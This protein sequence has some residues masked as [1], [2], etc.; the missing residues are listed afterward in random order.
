MLATFG[1]NYVERAP[2]VARTIEVDRTRARDC[3]VKA[4]KHDLD[5]VTMRIIAETEQR[6]TSRLNPFA[7]LERC[8]LHLYGIVLKLLGD[9]I[10][11]F[12]QLAL[13]KFA[14][15]GDRLLGN[16]VRQV[17][18]KGGGRFRLSRRAFGGD[19]CQMSPPG[20]PPRWE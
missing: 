19:D 9:A 11:K 18:A 15:H 1:I 7:K 12:S 10:E 5:G 17:N 2:L 20:G 8:N 13:A 4:S 6:K 16:E 3:H 14:A